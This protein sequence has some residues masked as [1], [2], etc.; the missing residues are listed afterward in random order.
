[1]AHAIALERI[2]FPNL[3]PA[4]YNYFSTGSILREEIEAEDI[5]AAVKFVIDQVGVYGSTNDVA[6]ML[7]LLLYHRVQSLVLAVDSGGDNTSSADITW[8][9]GRSL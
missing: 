7:A 4:C 8:S 2:G 3:A 5:D 1:M 9:I 6:V